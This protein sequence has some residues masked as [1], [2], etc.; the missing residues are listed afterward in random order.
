MLKYN[1]KATAFFRNSA[2][3]YN[4]QWLHKVLTLGNCVNQLLSEK[5]FTLFRKN[6]EEVIL[7]II[8][9]YNFSIFTSHK[10][11]SQ[12]QSK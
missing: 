1:N 7:Q 10:L 2:P 4:S 6:C 9:F 8:L 5:Q 11:D 3:I 12:T